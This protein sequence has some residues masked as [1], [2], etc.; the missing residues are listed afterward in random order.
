[1]VENDNVHVRT[2]NIFSDVQNQNLIFYVKSTDL[3]IWVKLF[4][5][6]VN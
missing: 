6:N 5:L 4:I 3:L 1:M 2:K